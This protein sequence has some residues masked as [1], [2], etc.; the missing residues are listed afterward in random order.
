VTDGPD[1]GQVVGPDVPE[2]ERARLRRVHDLLVAAGA[3]PE[4]PPALENAPN[5]GAASVSV[6]PRRRRPALLLIAAAL[7]AIAFGGGYLVAGHGRTERAAFESV[8]AVEMHG[9]EAAPN[10]L[11]RIDLGE[12]DRAGNWPMLVTVQG[13]PQLPKGAYYELYLTRKGKIAAPCGTFI[14]HAGTTRVYLNAPYKLKAFD[15]WVVTRHVAGRHES[16][17]ILTT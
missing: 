16:H 9:T 1:F 5:V 11:A 13:L 2:E 3:P 10:A 6:L 4:L 12:V 17:P 8:R 7:A 14:V 15:G